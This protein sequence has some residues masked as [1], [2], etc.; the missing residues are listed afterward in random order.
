MP[1]AAVS[2]HCGAIT[3][4][5]IAPAAAR[6]LASLDPAQREEFFAALAE[7]DEELRRE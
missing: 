6:W 4:A 5:G 1:R 3:V 7:R 2:R